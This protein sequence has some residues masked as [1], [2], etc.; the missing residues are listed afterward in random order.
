MAETK[1]KTIRLICHL[2]LLTTIV[3]CYGDVETNPG[4]KSNQGRVLIR[5]TILC[6]NGPV[7]EF[8]TATPPDLR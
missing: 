2:F 7:V 4:P 1:G 3:F 5:Q 8:P 6:N